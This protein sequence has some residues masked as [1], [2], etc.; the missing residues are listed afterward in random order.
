MPFLYEQGQYRQA[1]QLLSE[2]KIHA[3]CEIGPDTIIAC[4]LSA[5]KTWPS[6]GNSECDGAAQRQS[7]HNAQYIQ[8]L[9]SVE[10]MHSRRHSKRSRSARRRRFF[11]QKESKK[12]SRSLNSKM[13]PMKNHLSKNLDK[14]MR[15][16][17]R[18][19]T[20]SK[21]RRFF[22]QKESKGQGMPQE[23]LS[24]EEWSREA[25]RLLDSVEEVSIVDLQR[26]IVF[27]GNKNMVALL[28]GGLL[29]AQE[30]FYLCL[31]SDQNG[32]KT[33]ASALMDQH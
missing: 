18:K 25:Q 11:D 8:E 16:K 15:S 19:I 24:P 27:F 5:R 20:S 6:T 9:M 13:H 17:K 26:R 28:L 4:S 21:R 32:A 33:T 14:V 22:D 30:L 10:R 29:L 12:V 7:I 31:L 23:A 3:R 1:E 2:V